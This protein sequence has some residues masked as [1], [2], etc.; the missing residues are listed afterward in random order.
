[1]TAVRKITKTNIKM[2]MSYSIGLALEYGVEEAIILSKLMSFSK[3]RMRDDGF[4]WCL[5]DELEEQTGLTRPRIKHAI[6]SLEEEGFIYTKR[7]YIKD[8]QL[9]RSPIS[10]NHFK[11]NENKSI[12]IENL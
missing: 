12:V 6:K 10:C 11:I 8:R 9:W 1:M 5:Y 3:I 2:K 4:T 7:A